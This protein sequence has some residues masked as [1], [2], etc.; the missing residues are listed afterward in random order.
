MTNFP[1]K[2]LFLKVD[3]IAKISLKI[4]KKNLKTTKD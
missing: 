1:K 3:F 2:S 4:N